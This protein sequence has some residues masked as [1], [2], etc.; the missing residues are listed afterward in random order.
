[1]Q[2]INLQKEATKFKILQAKA[3]HNRQTNKKHF[4]YIFALF[5]VGLFSFELNFSIFHVVFI[6]VRYN[7]FAYPKIKKMRKEEEEKKKQKANMIQ[8]N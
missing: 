1:M 7:V 4:P 6:I 3:S 2:M 5:L 8:V